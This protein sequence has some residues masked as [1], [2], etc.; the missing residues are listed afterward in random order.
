MDLIRIKKTY[1][2]LLKLSKEN[3]KAML[4]N[5]SYVLKE[6]S[7]VLFNYDKDAYLNDKIDDYHFNN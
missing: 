6:G 5:I 3:L 7:S 2:S 4:N 1:V